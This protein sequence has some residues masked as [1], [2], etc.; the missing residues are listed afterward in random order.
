MQE[1][2]RRYEK[3]RLDFGH[4]HSKYMAK[5][6]KD[7][8]LLESAQEVAALRRDFHE[9]SLDYAIVLNE[10]SDKKN[11]LVYQSSL[12]QL[13]CRLEFAEREADKLRAIKGHLEQLAAENIADG[14]TMKRRMMDAVRDKHSLM[15]VVGRDGMGSS[16]SL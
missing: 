12:N 9:A 3:T 5:R 11:V 4:A 1:S 8:G 15:M 16:C 2:K 10:V 13:S 7:V 6:A 14:D